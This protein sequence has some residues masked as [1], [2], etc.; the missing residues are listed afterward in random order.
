[1]SEQIFFAKSLN[2]LSDTDA[3]YLAPAHNGNVSSAF[4][5]RVWPAAGNF[6][7]MRVRLAVA[8]GAGK[9]RTF[10]LRKLTGA[11]RSVP[12]TATALTLTISGTDTTGEAVIDAAISPGD[13]IVIECSPTSTPAL[14]RVQITTT[15]VPTTANET[16]LL[17]G[18]VAGTVTR[19]I[20][21]YA[22]A[23]TLTSEDRG[24]LPLPTPGTFKNLYIDADDTSGSG[25]SRTITV[26]K[27]GT[28]TA[29]AA[30]MGAASDA[31]SNTSD[32]FTGAI[33]D[34]L[35]MQL[36]ITGTP[37]S[38]AVRVAM[39]F[40]P[41]NS[42]EFLSGIACGQDQHT[43][44]L[45]YGPFHGSF[46]TGAD[47]DAEV[48]VDQLAL[49]ITILKMYAHLEVAPGSGNSRT[50][51]FRK[52]GTSSP[53]AVTVSDANITGNYTTPLGASLDQ[54]ISTTEDTS[55]SPTTS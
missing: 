36:D 12:G 5:R 40:V 55:G 20:P 54:L 6:T 37:S 30:T 45:L 18:I 8:P 3:Q 51:T 10:T 34:L 33:D 19:W 21:F 43:T 1:M 47:G 16:V 28:S 23:G 26:R 49:D 24:K 9:S 25:N 50:F 7:K 44:G 46:A 15:F 4:G 52:N 13:V 22:L 14:S 31:A 41:D 48:K 39:V 29:L 32:S 38:N 11:G 42:G 2:L 35:S 17:G 27:N 53:M